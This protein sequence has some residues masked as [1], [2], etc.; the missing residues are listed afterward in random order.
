MRNFQK[1]FTDK[2]IYN[3]TVRGHLKMA[4]KPAGFNFETSLNYN[5][6]LYFLFEKKHQSKTD[7]AF[8]INTELSV[9][10]KV[11]LTL[12]SQTYVN[13]FFESVGKLDGVGLQNKLEIYP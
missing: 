13:I 4:D 5:Q 8:S 12:V 9:I 2:F 10:P 7:E 1:F 11:P 6:L 3:N